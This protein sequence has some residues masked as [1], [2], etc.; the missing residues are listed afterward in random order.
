MDIITSITSITAWLAS[1]VGK[2]LAI[3]VAGRLLWLWPQFFNGAIPA[4]TAGVNLLLTVLNLLA[5]AASGTAMLQ[6]G[7][8]K[9]S[10]RIISGTGDKAG[11]ARL[12]RAASGGMTGPATF[13]TTRAVL[14]AQDLPR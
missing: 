7:T 8:P 12:H 14:C 13:A 10:L 5:Q 2:T 6:A 4:G 11:A 9:Q 1:P 3:Y